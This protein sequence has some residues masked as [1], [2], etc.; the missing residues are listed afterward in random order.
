MIENTVN[1]IVA[2]IIL[3]VLSYGIGVGVALA[4]KY[5]APYSLWTWPNAVRGPISV[6]VAYF[7]IQLG[8]GVGTLLEPEKTVFELV[9]KRHYERLMKVPEFQQRTSGISSKD[10]AQK[11]GVEIARQGLARL[12]D[13]SL[14]SYVSL[15]KK[16]LASSDAATC[17]ALFRGTATASQMKAALA[18]LDSA[19]INAWEDISFKAAVAELKVSPVPQLNERD[20]AQAFDKLFK[21][22]TPDQTDRIDAV[23][24]GRRS[25]TD[26]ETCSAGRTFYDTV[27]VM[28]E[29][30]SHVLTRVLVQR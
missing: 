28:D 2:N 21:L 16:I 25:I 30:Y 17:A 24:T 7:I 19:S 26:I 15:V 6:A 14:Q 1:K 23:L 22:L 5:P 18:T 10:E 11:L 13:D 8:A 4:K 20:R 3:V 29:P 27:S 9:A 12:D